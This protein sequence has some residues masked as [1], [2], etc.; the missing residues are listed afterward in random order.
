MVVGCATLPVM[1]PIELQ[2]RRDTFL[3]ERCA[4]P[5]TYQEK[6]FAWV[7]EDTDRG[8]TQGMTLAQM[9]ALKVQ[10]RTAIAAGYWPIVLRTSTKFGPDTLTVLVL[11]HQLIRI[12]PG[13]DEDD[14]E[15]CICPGLG[16]VRDAAGTPLRTERSALAVDWLEKQLVPHLKV[17]GEA[18]LRIERGPSW[19][20]ARAV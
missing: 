19:T 3:P 17:G 13:N 4:G 20:P 11:G 16:L 1:Q 9:Q 8:L 2:L 5:L 15:G 18:W 6:P 7:V 12:H 10:G 14:T